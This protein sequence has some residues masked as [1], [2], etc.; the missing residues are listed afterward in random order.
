MRLIFNEIIINKKLSMLTDKE[1]EQIKNAIAWAEKATSGE[2][3][4][5]IE[6]KCEIDAY[7]R[8]IACFADLDM[9][10]TKLRNGILVYIALDDHKFAIIGDE[11]INKLVS[12]TFWD[13]TKNLML[14]KFKV[15]DL[16]DG[17]SVGIIEAGKQLKK[18]YPYQTSDINEL[19]DDIV[20]LN[21]K[22]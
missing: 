5:C 7:D 11:G 19:S 9:H 2:V 21:N 10:Q 12:D 15:G 14:E 16:V 18:Y 8:A 3:R 22:I 17:I 6:D 20:F 1:Q 4:V 13:S